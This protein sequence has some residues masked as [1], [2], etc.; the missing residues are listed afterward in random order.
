MGH[1]KRCFPVVNRHLLMGITAIVNQPILY[2]SPVDQL[3][4]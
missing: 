3:T 4:L 1:Q 2:A